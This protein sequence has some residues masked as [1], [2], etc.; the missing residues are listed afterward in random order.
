[1]FFIY[2]LIFNEILMVNRGSI[3]VL[4]VKLSS[5]ESSS[6][7]DVYFYKRNNKYRTVQPAL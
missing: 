6:V 5:W 4:N 3:W 1:M 2:Y 7:R